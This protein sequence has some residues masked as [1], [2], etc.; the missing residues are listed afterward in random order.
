VVNCLAATEAVGSTESAAADCKTAWDIY[1]AR[2]GA[3]MCY[4]AAV[5]CATAARDLGARDPAF[6]LF[7]DTAFVRLDAAPF[8]AVAA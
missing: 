6:A 5:A 1:V 4:A 7:E 2:N 3:C 8:V